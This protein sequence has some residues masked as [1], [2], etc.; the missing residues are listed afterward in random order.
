M[1]GQVIYYTSRRFIYHLSLKSSRYI[2]D[3]A[4]S[5]F[6]RKLQGYQSGSASILLSVIRKNYRDI[7]VSAYLSFISSNP[8]SG[9]YLNHLEETAVSTFDYV[10]LAVCRIDCKQDIAYFTAKRSKNYRPYSSKIY[11]FKR[12]LRCLVRNFRKSH[13][14]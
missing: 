5:N 7:Y 13:S 1:S 6:R 8:Y 3:L 14:L 9:G 2:Y 12:Q 4:L 11:S 10:D